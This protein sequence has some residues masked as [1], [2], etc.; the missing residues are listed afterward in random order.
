[1][2]QQDDKAAS[3]PNDNPFMDSPPGSNN[4]GGFDGDDGANHFRLQDNN[5]A[6]DHDLEENPFGDDSDEINFKQMSSPKMDKY[7]NIAKS[8]MIDDPKS[9]PPHQMM[10][11]LPKMQSEYVQ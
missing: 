3:S 6:A 4:P 1:M 11:E 8:A 2:M 9:L 5:A 10:S 7:S